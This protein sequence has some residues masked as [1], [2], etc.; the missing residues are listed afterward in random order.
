MTLF[1][2]T[3]GLI[4]GCPPRSTWTSSPSRR[5]LTV[6]H[7]PISGSVLSMSLGTSSAMD[8]MFRS[9]NASCPVHWNPW[10][11]PSASAKN[12]SLRTPVNSRTGPAWT[13]RALASKPTGVSRMSTSPAGSGWRALSPVA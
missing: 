2:L 5:T 12:G 1:G 11:E 6:A 8:K 3:N 9:A 10:K 4:V 7:T 13:D